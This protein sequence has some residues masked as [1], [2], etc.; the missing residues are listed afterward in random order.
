MNSQ[1]SRTSTRIFEAAGVGFAG[2]V[3]TLALGAP[4]WAAPDP[5]A[6]YPGGGSDDRGGSVTTQNVATP[7]ALDSSWELT[8]VAT[9]VLGGL[10]LAAAGFAAVEVTRRRTHHGH[11]VG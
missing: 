1:N 8:Q 11:A 3:A 10:G 6:G 9:G 4:A 7:A 5:G 2:V